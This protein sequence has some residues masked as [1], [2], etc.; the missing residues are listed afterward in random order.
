MSP[1]CSSQQSGLGT[2]R[3]GRGFGPGQAAKT[4]NP[5]PGAAQ[6]GQ[7]NKQKPKGRERKDT[8]CCPGAPSRC[9]RARGFGRAAL[10]QEQVPGA[11][12]C[13][14]P[15]PER[16]LLPEA[17]VSDFRPPPPRPL[18]LSASVER[19]LIREKQHHCTFLPKIPKDLTH[20]TSTRERRQSRKP[21][22]SL[23]GGAGNLEREPGTQLGQGSAPD[24]QTPA[25]TQPAP[26]LGGQSGHS[27]PTGQP[28]R[29]SLT[30]AFF[31]S[32]GTS[33]SSSWKSRWKKNKRSRSQTALAAPVSPVSARPQQRLGAPPAAPAD[34]P[35][36]RE[37]DSVGAAAGGPVRTLT[38]AASNSDHHRLFPLFPPHRSGHLFPTGHA[39]WGPDPGRSVCGRQGWAE[40]AGRG[41]RG[42]DA[43]SPVLAPSP[44]QAVLRH[45]LLLLL[46]KGN[47]QSPGSSANPARTGR[48]AADSLHAR[49]PSQPWGRL[50]PH[51]LR[52]RSVCTCP[53]PARLALPWV[54][55][56]APQTSPRPA[57]CLSHDAS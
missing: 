55:A 19:M 39:H 10:R 44:R 47:S 38:P 35:A 20:S 11:Q 15:R 22:Q 41:P 18:L 21:S 49:A 33:V 57:A 48:R 8:W 54:P 12:A 51:G 40:P 56:R 5:N 27:S 6:H 52:A 36:G 37:L 7:E 43:R 2:P 16:G 50:R 24:P 32:S 28:H 25:C 42:A 53:L 13:E 3:S 9:S 46:Q 23:A 17:N 1:R 30:H 14:L 45:L 26:L 29:R 34:R 31:T 4:P